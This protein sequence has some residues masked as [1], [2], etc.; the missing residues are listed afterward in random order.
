MVF[1]YVTVFFGGP[2]VSVDE[3]ARTR[4]WGA[5]HEAF[6]DIVS[7]GL[8]CEVKPVCL[9]VSIVYLVGMTLFSCPSLCI[10][11][12][13]REPQEL[14]LHVHHELRNLKYNN[15]LLNTSRT[16][17]LHAIAMS[18]QC[19]QDLCGK[20][21]WSICR[22]KRPGRLIFRSNKKDS[23][24]HQ[25]PSVLCTPP[26]GKSPIKSDWFCVLPPLKNHPSKPHR[27]C[28][29]PPLENHPSKAIGFVYSPLW[30][31]TH[32]PIKTH[33]VSKS[34]CFGGCL[35]WFGVGVYF[36][37][38]G[39]AWDDIHADICIN[40]TSGANSSFKHIL[41]VKNYLYDAALIRFI[42]I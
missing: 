6:N 10:V 40:C 41:D 23:K 28:V 17:K 34:H 18:G 16:C 26:S 25:T 27:F 36:G 22:N 21:K 15:K 13:L 14:P 35:I 2:Y 33:Q 5:H 30:K 31:I 12:I 37:K 42:E 19:G 7:R 32:Q 11:L 1:R 8:P 20:H 24:T 38:Y 9:K 4:H 39:E 29:L 3:L